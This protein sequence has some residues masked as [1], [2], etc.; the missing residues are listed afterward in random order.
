[1]ISPVLLFTLITGIIGAFQVF[2]PAYIISGGNNLGAPAYS[3]MFYNLYL[4]VNAFRT[5]RMGLASAQAWILLVV[6]LLL[7]LLMF[8]ASRRFVYYESDEEGAI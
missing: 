6:V 4:F 3:S 7:T 1:M 2:T 5:F 8:W